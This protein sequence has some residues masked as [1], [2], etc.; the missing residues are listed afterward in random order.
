MAEE[1]KKQIFRQKSLDR[2]SSPEQL[3]DYL[4]VT[5]VGV[6]VLL[7][8]IILL[9]AAFFAW[10]SI[11]KLETTAAAK[12]AVMDG[13]AQITVIDNAKVASGMAVRMGGAEFKISEV[14]L[15]E[16][17]FTL[18]YAP[19]DLANGSYDAEVVVESVSPISFLLA[20]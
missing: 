3:T 7:S 5:N 1:Q 20:S 6:W 18:A 14:D 8:V 17:G 19:V 16:L 13:T 4:H 15:D 12:A 10:A 9:L 11:R 2:I